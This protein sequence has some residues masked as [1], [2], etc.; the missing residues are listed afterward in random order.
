VKK[1]GVPLKKL[2]F[3]IKPIVLKTTTVKERIFDFG[4]PNTKEHERDGCLKTKNLETTGAGEKSDP[5]EREKRAKN[6]EGRRQLQ[7]LINKRSPSM[8]L[9]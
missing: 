4:G 9:K 2:I 8:G 5:S 7:W 1:K 6:G 3:P